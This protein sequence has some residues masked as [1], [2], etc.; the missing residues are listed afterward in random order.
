MLVQTFIIYA[1]TKIGDSSPVFNQHWISVNQLATKG[2]VLLSLKVRNKYNKQNL[3]S[4]PHYHDTQLKMGKNNSYCP[5]QFEQI[6]LPKTHFIRLI[7]QIEND[8]V[9]LN[10]LKG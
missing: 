1:F 4:H 6:L 2:A 10:E 5:V 7:K 3:N 9:T 8:I